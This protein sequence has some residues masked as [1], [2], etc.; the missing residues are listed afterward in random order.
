MGTEILFPYDKEC[1]IYNDMG[2][3]GS[4]SGWDQVFLSAQYGG[5]PALKCPRIDVIELNPVKP[6]PRKALLDYVFSGRYIVTGDGSPPGGYAVTLH[7]DLIDQGHGKKVISANANWSC[8][9]REAGDCLRVRLEETVRLART[10]QP[11]DS[12]IYEYERIPETA[13]VELEKDPILAGERMKIVLRNLADANSKPSQSW[14]RILIKVEKGRI[15]NGESRGDFK[16][17]QVGS[18]TVEVEYQAPDSCKNDVETLTVMNSCTI[19]PDMPAIPESEIVRQTF[20]IFCVEGKIRITEDWTSSHPLKSMLVMPN[21]GY[22]G[23]ATKKVPAFLAFRLKP[24]KDPCLYEVIDK[25]SSPSVYEERY[26]PSNRKCCDYQYASSK[27]YRLSDTPAPSVVDLRNSP[28]K[29]LSVSITNRHTY[30]AECLNAPPRS[31][32]RKIDY[33]GEWDLHNNLWPLKNGHVDDIK[34]SRFELIIDEK[35][36]KELKNRCVRGK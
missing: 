32:L 12:F 28:E 22:Q 35:E 21:C 23:G 29:F 24:T 30:T 10:F 20:N 18:G 27:L 33:S 16:V 31:P 4:D 6:V 19:R 15:L 1:K 13:R 17:F 11:L 25:G 26:V 34:T 8:V 3:I 9:R 2:Y 14:Q 36:V 7:V 5:G